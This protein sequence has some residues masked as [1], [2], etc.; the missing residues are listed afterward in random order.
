[1]VMRSSESDSAERAQT[2]ASR[3]TIR[4]LNSKPY[5]SEAEHVDVMASETHTDVEFAENYGATMVPAKQDEEEEG[6]GGQGQ[7]AEQGEGGGGAGGAGGG[8]QGEQ[9]KQPKGDAA[10]AIVLYLNGSRSHPVIISCGDRRHRLLELEEGDVANHRLKDD[11]QQFLMAKDGTYMTTRKDKV[12]R[13]ALVEKQDDS[14]GGQQQQ[15]PSATQTATESGGSA[16]SGGQ[17]QKKKKTYGQKS[18][19]DDNKGSKINIEQKG[20]ATTVQHEDSYSVQRASD[21]STYYKDRTKST[22]VTD[23]HAHLRTKGMK[24]FTD[25]GG[26]WSEVPMLV[27]KDGYCKS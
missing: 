9:G 25:E 22:Q 6:Q 12:F 21:S 14:G 16:S 5:W 2:S 20:D 26:C 3:A 18:A 4:K 19:K 10:E 27:K 23:S 24:I 8:S 15:Q 11:R 1:M 7:D 17:Q 13:I